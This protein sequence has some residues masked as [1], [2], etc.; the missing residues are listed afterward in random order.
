MN[1]R[2]FLSINAALVLIVALTSIFFPAT[3]MELL[4]EEINQSLLGLNRSFGAVIIGNALISWLLRS[5]HPSP[6]RKAFLLGAAVNYLVFAAVIVANAQAYPS[7]NTSVAYGMAGL[8]L[9]MGLG[10]VNFWRQELA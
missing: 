2:N 4:N 8:N 1:V 5:Q 10:F 6:A 3:L 7:V 9:L